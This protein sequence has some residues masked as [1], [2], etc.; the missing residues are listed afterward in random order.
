MSQILTEWTGRRAPDGLTS[1]DDF[2][3]EDAG[4][5]ADNRA[6]LDAGL[7]AESDLAANDGA[8]ADLDSA[9][10]SG[11]SGDDDVSADFAVMADVDHVVDLRAIAD[12]GDAEGGAI[13]AGVSSEFDVVAED[14]AAD[15]WEV[16]VVILFPHV[17]EAVGAQNYAGVQHD[18][19]A[20]LDIGIQCDVRMQ[21]A[22]LTNAAAVADDAVGSDGGARVDARSR[23]NDSGFVNTGGDAARMEPTNRL[24]DSRTWIGGE[25]AGASG[26]RVTGRND[27]ASGFSVASDIGELEAGDE[28]DLLGSGGFERRYALNFEVAIPFETSR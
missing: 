5:G 23:T 9:R 6:G 18:A 20:E 1:A 26:D 3:G 24:G 21:N 4:S 11:L 15:L 8:V 14:D 7:V 22:L 25:D 27:E 19:V 13:D 28:C 16:L 2:A 10:E 17:S 12:F